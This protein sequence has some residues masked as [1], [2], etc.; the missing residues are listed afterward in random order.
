MDISGGSSS[1][2]G[3]GGGPGGGS[4]SGRYFAAGSTSEG[5]PVRRTGV[6]VFPA[7]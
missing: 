6:R 3:G 7:V 5:A 1:S 4:G 2:G